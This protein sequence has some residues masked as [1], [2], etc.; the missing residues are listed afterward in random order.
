MIAVISDAKAKKVI[1]KNVIARLRELNQSRYWLAKQTKKRESTIANVCTAR[2]C[3]N[4]ALLAT[5]AEALGVSTDFL[6]TDGPRP[7]KPK[8]ILESA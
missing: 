1:A 8:K 6:L 2:S 7:A 5:I 4:A 3:C